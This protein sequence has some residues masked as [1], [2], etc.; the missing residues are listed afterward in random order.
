MTSQ[1]LA[2]KAKSQKALYFKVGFILLLIL[3]LLIPT[4]FITD[5]IHERANLQR[6]TRYEIAQSWG[7]TQVITGPV[8]SIPYIT[9]YSGDGKPSLFQHTL[10]I[11]PTEV[12]VSSDV[13]TEERAK[14]IYST[15]LYTA[16]NDIS[17][18]FEL[19]QIGDFGAN[20]HEVRWS[21]ARVL[22]P[23]SQ[24]TSIISV[25]NLDAV[26]EQYRMKAIKDKQLGS[27]LSATVDITDLSELD[28]LATISTKGSESVE[29]VPS[30]ANQVVDM[31]CDWPS[32]GFGG[33]TLPVQRQISDA[34]FTARW[35]ANEYS[36]PMPDM[37]K[38]DEYKADG[39]SSFGV[40]LVQTVDHY[41]KNL[42]SVKY[43]LLIIALSFLIFFF[44]EMMKGRRIHPLQ[45][46]LIG[47]GL[48]LFYLLLLSLSEHVGFDWAY[49][50]AAGATTVLVVW[51]SSA[52][53]GAGRSVTTLGG[54]LAALYAYI[55][56]LLQMEDYALLAGSL[57]LF[58]ILAA[59][60]GMTRRLNW[61]EQ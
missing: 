58:L 18:R 59:V 36:R 23:V 52:V 5:L 50:A 8:L 24:P 39:R 10:Y 44:F 1:E 28:I 26:D 3:L 61:Y 25:V 60:M 22:I 41:Q 57:G 45:Y 17:G 21:E 51:Y 9:K 14:G 34:E 47:L 35:T 32:P 55:F 46:I 27:V 20:V 29:F 2:S 43:S 53:L 12:S 11:S 37:W 40:Q 13:K 38:D 31:T 4:A 33:G 15:I 16:A 30:G 19:P 7:S 42:R 54:V 48:S 56:V 49:L 6:Q